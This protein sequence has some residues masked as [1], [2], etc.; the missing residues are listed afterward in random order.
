MERLLD[1]CSDD[2]GET[3]QR[4]MSLLLCYDRLSILEIQTVP[5]AMEISCAKDI[6]RYSYARLEQSFYLF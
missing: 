3:K 4:P 6:N 2:P 5:V 1:F